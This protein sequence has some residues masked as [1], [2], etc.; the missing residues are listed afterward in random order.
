[1][2]SGRAHALMER[3]GLSDEELCR[4]L[5][6]DPLAILSGQEDARP[7]LGILLD[8]TAEAE[9]RVGG[10]QLRAWVRRGPLEHL[11]ARDFAA[12]EDDLAGLSERG[13]VIRAD[14][15]RRPPT[16]S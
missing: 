14:S 11:L 12:F 3:L 1:M 9:E 4:V 10:A 13:W 7:E 16:G 8:L 15:G 6:T 5:D 2:T